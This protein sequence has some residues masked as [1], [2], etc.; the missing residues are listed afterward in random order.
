MGALRPL[1]FAAML[2]LARPAQAQTVADWRPFMAEASQRFGM[3][4]SW[5]ERV[6]QAESGGRTMLN[7]HPIVSRAGAMGLM[8]LMPGT[9]DEMRTLLGLGSD[10]FDPRDNI[11]AGTAYLRRMY[12]RFGYPGMFAAYNAGPGR[13]AAW[14]A[15]RATLPNETI[16]YLGSVSGSRSTPTT[17]GALALRATIFVPLRASV[18]SG[19][20]VSG[21]ASLNQLFAVRKR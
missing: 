11:L 3:P 13:Y 4:I 2:M 1:A 14:L 5:I 15:G 18:D 10:P 17:V 6:M 12:D 16:A 9:W 8:Q 20:P 7:G 19:A 21:P